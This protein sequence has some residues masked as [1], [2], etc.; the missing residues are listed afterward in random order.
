MK[1]LFTKTI[2]NVRSAITLATIFTLIVFSN[3]VNATIV[4]I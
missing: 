1:N 3:I 2:L 4:N